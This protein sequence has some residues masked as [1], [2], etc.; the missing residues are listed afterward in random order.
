MQKLTITEVEQ[1]RLFYGVKTA[2]QV[3][4]DYRVSKG[5][6]Q[7]IWHGRSWTFQINK[8][9]ND[10]YD[11]PGY[12]GLYQ[13]NRFGAV[14]SCISYKIL[15]PGITTKGYCQVLLIKNYVKKRIM[16]HKLVVITFIGYV[17]KGYQINHKN[18]NKRDNR[19]RNLE[20]VTPKQNV[21]HAKKNGR[22]KVGEAC[23]YSKL[24]T[25][26]VMEI[27]KLRGVKT[28]KEIAKMYHVGKTCIG[29]IFSGRTWK[30]VA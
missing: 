19:L 8:P 24:T 15:S 30:H 13:I 4:N 3:A 28:A 22:I 17:R 5:T 26:Q 10:F 14:Y 1:I 16:V 7:S 25:I 20:I 27:K 2:K 12:K 23:V 21:R 11:I 6:I 29:D 18:C 9:I